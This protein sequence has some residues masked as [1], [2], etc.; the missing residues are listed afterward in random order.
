MDMTKSSATP[1][2]VEVVTSVQVK[3]EV[4]GAYVVIAQFLSV[5]VRLG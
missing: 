3:Y 4:I 5:M 1:S 2:R